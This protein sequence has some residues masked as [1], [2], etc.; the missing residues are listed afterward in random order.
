MYFFVH[1][2]R[3]V[4]NRQHSRQKVAFLSTENLCWKGTDQ[5]KNR[6]NIWGGGDGCS[7]LD[8]A[9]MAVATNFSLWLQ[10]GVYQLDQLGE[11]S[12]AVILP[13]REVW[14]FALE[15]NNGTGRVSL[16]R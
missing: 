5:A 13:F 2:Q 15:Q 3:S 11:K 6:Q 8:S 16:K 14:S 12:T 10:T 7:K 9:C 4:L 1:V